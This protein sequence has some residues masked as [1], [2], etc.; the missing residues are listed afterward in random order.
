M[1]YIKSIASIRRPL[2]IT[3][4]KTLIQSLVISRLDYANRLLSGVS[5][6]ELRRL[7]LIQNAAA[8]LITNTK[9]YEHVTLVLVELHWLPIEVRILFKTLVFVTVVFMGPLLHI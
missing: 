1:F 5:K 4:T 6:L 7:H 2:D 9:I 3:T 8:M